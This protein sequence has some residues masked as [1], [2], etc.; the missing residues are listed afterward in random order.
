[1][2]E[3]PTKHLNYLLSGSGAAE[4]YLSDKHLPTRPPCTCTKALTEHLI[5]TSKT[6][7]E[8]GSLVLR[9]THRFH[10]DVIRLTHRRAPKLI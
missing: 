8:L 2:Q 3:S 7:Q 4:S 6:D 1:M 5:P 9:K 10:F